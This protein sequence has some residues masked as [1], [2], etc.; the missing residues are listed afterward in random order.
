MRWLRSGSRN[1]AT[2]YPRE[3][4]L[5]GLADALPAWEAARQPHSA[6]QPSLRSG[7]GRARPPPPAAAPGSS[8]CPSRSR[9]YSS[10]AGSTPWGGGAGKSLI[11][12]LGSRDDLAPLAENPMLLTS[13]CVLYDKGRRLPE[14]RYDSTRVSS[15]ACFTAAIRATPGSGS[16]PEAARG[17][18]LRD[19]PGEP[20]K[21]GARPPPPRSAGSRPTHARRLRGEEPSLGQGEVDAADQREELLTRSGLLLPRPNERAA[22]Y[23]LS[24][25]EFL[26]AQRIARA[27]DNLGGRGHRSARG[28]PGVARDPFVSVRRPDLQ[29]G[30][31]VGARACSNGCSKAR[32]APRSR[33]T[34]RRRRSSPRRW[35]CAWPSAIGFPRPGREL[36]PA[37]PGRIDDEIELHARQTLGLCLGRLGDPRIFDLR[38]PRPTSR[39]R[40]GPIPMAKEGKTVK[41]E[42]PFLLGRYPVTNSQYQAFMDD[43]GYSDRKWWSDA[44]WAWLTE[45][46]D[47]GAWLLAR[48][49]LEW[50]Q[51]AGGRGQLLGGRGLLRLGRR[52][53]AARAG[54]GGRRPRSGGL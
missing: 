16:R 17:D 1:G 13:M 35:S 29:Q 11:E 43:G 26:A 5:S 48:P 44:G 51:P 28:G 22:F 21:R 18:R 19:A 7:R 10:H 45:G 54:M 37:Q 30:P 39:C 25:Q 20:A 3:V 32:T 40:P 27:S 4:L 47:H 15:T 33:P 12:A 52:A 34:R 2:V 49:A 41:I 50:P 8:H 9:S 53:P 31:R 36:P 24:F 23:H 6:D 42:A 38:D 46:R 14:D